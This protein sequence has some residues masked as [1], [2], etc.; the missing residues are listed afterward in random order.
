MLTNGTLLYSVTKNTTTVREW[1]M[2]TIKILHNLDAEILS[3][4]KIAA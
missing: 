3:E 4:V 1:R 2:E